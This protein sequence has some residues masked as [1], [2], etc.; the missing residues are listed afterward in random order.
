[1]DGIEC[2]PTRGLR[3]RHEICIHPLSVDSFISAELK[4]IGRWEYGIGEMMMM[5][6]MR[7]DPRD[8]TFVDI[9]AHIGPHSLYAAALGY[10]VVAVEPAA[11]NHLRIHK[12]VKI[13]KFENRFTL[14][15]YA[16]LDEYRTV[17]LQQDPANLGRNKIEDLALQ[18]A[19]DNLKNVSI[20]AQ[21]ILL[22]DLLPFVTTPFVIMKIDV[23]SYECNV[24]NSGTC[25]F[26]EKDGMISRR[27]LNS[28][29]CKW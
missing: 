8:V 22:D 2:V 26:A 9:G 19:K 3:A 23:E 10:P 28:S 24:I 17:V 12:S 25:F 16:M 6:L 18:K 14:L 5:E 1:M 11:F 21:T 20:T 13:N 7:F 15:P 27:F 4:T 29:Q